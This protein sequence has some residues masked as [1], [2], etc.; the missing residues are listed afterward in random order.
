MVTIAVGRNFCHIAGVDTDD[1]IG[2]LSRQCAVYFRVAFAGIADEDFIP[3]LADKNFLYTFVV[4]EKES[5]TL[6][7][8]ERLIRS[9]LLGLQL[10]RL[11]K[12]GNENAQLL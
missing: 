9:Y 1:L 2:K 8:H 7:K 10:H 3:A 5:R 11:T 12:R 6:A 4:H